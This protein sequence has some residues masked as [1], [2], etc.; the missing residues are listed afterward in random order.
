M[1]NDKDLLLFRCVKGT[2]S[3]EELDDAKRLVEESEK[4]RNIFEQLCV[5][6]HWSEVL[7]C[8]R[9]ADPQSSFKQVKRKMRKNKI[10]RIVVWTQRVAAMLFIPLLCSVVYFSQFQPQ[11]TV[12]LQEQP[13]P[14]EIISAPGLVTI[15]VLPDSTKVWLNSGSTI[16]YPTFFAG[17]TR[18]VTLSGEAYFA[19]AKNSEKPFIL[20]VND[21]FNV[22]VTGTEFNAQAYPEA[23]TFAVT[24]A[25][26]SVELTSIDEPEKPMLTLNPG[27]QSVWNV[28]E[29]TVEVNKVNTN[30][31]AS[32]KDGKII[33]KNTS[34]TEII[35]TLERRYNAH[36]VI[37]PRLTGY[38]FT[39]TFT[40]A[41]LVQ[42]LEHFR[43]SS[44]ITYEIIDAGMND[45][46][47]VKQTIVHLK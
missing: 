5:I 36:F 40:N 45:D 1:E 4:A 20:N 33:F 7:E 34:M 15:V 9:K 27:E 12:A 8:M 31:I 46:G 25:E 19:V 13:Q 39:G 37:A 41:Q 21:A 32:W 3:Q 38:S 47:T 11:S 26:G 24:L 43:V 30:A 29:K 44:N 42:I 23:A 35:T 2:A 22:K 10:H 14:V 17:N 16:K 28:I 18:E 6:E